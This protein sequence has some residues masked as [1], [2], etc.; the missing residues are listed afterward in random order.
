MFIYISKSKHSPALILMLV[1]IFFTGLSSCK[2]DTETKPDPEPEPPVE[3]KD[4]LVVTFT[5][6]DLLLHNPHRGFQT[7]GRPLSN[8]YELTKYDI[9]SSSIYRRF[10]WYMLEPQEGVYDFS[11]IDNL[12]ASGENES[13][14][15]SFRIMCIAS[16]GDS[17]NVTP[18]WFQNSNCNHWFLEGVNYIP[19]MDDPIFKEHMYALIRKLGERYGNDPRVDMVDIGVVGLWGEWHNGDDT[20]FPLPSPEN[21]KELVDLFFEAFPNQY[22]IINIE[23][24]EDDILQYAVSKGCGVRTDGMGDKWHENTFF[25]E[26][27][28]KVPDA[29]K[30]APIE[31][32]A[33][34]L[35]NQWD[36]NSWHGGQNNGLTETIDN[37]LSRHYSFFNWMHGSKIASDEMLAEVSRFEKR[38]G[39]RLVLKRYFSQQ[40]IKTGD[41]L[42]IEIVWENTGVAPPYWDYYLSYLLVDE[43]GKENKIITGQSI[44]GW[45]P[46][47]TVNKQ[48]L[49]LPNS[50]TEGDYSI[51]VGLTNPEGNPAI[52]LAIDSERKGNWYKMGIIRIGNNQNGK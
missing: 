6:T 52:Q 11:K 16:P 40:S 31:G 18:K 19:D 38:L 24:F 23:S 50:I 2:K 44:K 36:D 47:T 29:W 41:T 4:S 33:Y 12:L 1:F 27:Y 30:Y 9:P 48:E 43:N 14:R 13:Q 34:Q 17:R 8:E 49:L 10:Y 26:N 35:I 3:I 51:Y 37:A 39:Y 5:E 45:L 22:K 7:E 25:P 20:D 42:K 46:G 32:E 15:F 28:A 21:R